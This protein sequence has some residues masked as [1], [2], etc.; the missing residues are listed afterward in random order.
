MEYSKLIVQFLNQRIASYRI[1]SVGIDG[2]YWNIKRSIRSYVPALA[3]TI[4][5]DSLVFVRYNDTSA[6][7]EVR[8]GDTCALWYVADTMFCGT[9]EYP[10]PLVGHL[11]NVLNGLWGFQVNAA[12]SSLSSDTCNLVSGGIPYY[13]A[14]NFYPTL[15]P[16]YSAF[17]DSVK[18]FP[19]G[20]INGNIDDKPLTNYISISS[21]G[22]WAFRKNAGDSLLYKLGAIK[23]KEVGAAMVEL[24]ANVLP[25]GY[26]SVTSTLF[27][28]QYPDNADNQWSGGA[29]ISVT[30][31]KTE[32][33]SFL[34]NRYT[35][36]VG[37]FIQTSDGYLGYINKWSNPNDTVKLFHIRFYSDLTRKL[38]D[39]ICSPKVCPSICFRWIPR[40]DSTLRIDTVKRISCR[41]TALQMIH[42][43]VYQQIG[44]CVDAQVAGLEAHYDAVCGNGDSL[45]DEIILQYPIDYYHFTLFYYDRSGNVVKVVAPKGVKANPTGTGD[46]TRMD[47]PTHTYITEYDYNSL[48]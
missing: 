28:H 22:G 19:F 14:F 41:E 36:T 18:I 1:D 33:L 2:G 46:P 9:P 34:N 38:A 7:F 44:T 10:H 31:S 13:R 26:G 48:G 40:K 24:Y 12:D 29:T 4:S 3:S 5:G 21:D 42:D 16:G 15:F 32:L 43:A 25:S 23:M 27:N 30:P 37:Q 35:D 17:I 8:P 11:N 47:H 39:D 6:H 20:C 45:K